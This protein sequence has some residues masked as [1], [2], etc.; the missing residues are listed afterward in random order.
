MLWMILRT[1]HQLVAICFPLSDWSMQCDEKR[2]IC[3]KC[4]K[5]RRSCGGWREKWDLV[6]RDEG[7]R[8]SQKSKADQQ[9]SDPLVERSCSLPDVRRRKQPMQVIK[10]QFQAYTPSNSIQRPLSIPIE[11]MALFYFAASYSSIHN[12]RSHTTQPLYLT[13]FDSLYSQER[14]GSLLE[15]TGKAV[16][17]AAFGIHQRDRNIILRSHERY[18][19]AMKLARKEFA[20]PTSAPS[21]PTHLAVI[22]FSLY[23]VS[24]IRSFSLRGCPLPWNPSNNP[25]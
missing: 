25:G 2:P 11:T 13:T 15:V 23:E 5:T 4:A 8:M 9:G 22:L 21:N 3:T 16:S 10:A 24:S 19:E 17:L 12:C 20:P 6:F 18:V 7:L 1:Y 14:E